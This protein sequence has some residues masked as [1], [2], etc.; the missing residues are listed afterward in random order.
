MNHE[1][2]VF[3]AGLSGEQAPSV[4]AAFGTFGCLG[5]VSQ[6]VSFGFLLHQGP[7]VWP[8][9]GVTEQ[10]ARWVEKMRVAGESDQEPATEVSAFTKR[11]RQM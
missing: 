10:L 7:Q 8:K 5:E 6:L 11:V 1:V 4:P 3:L 2:A 9:R